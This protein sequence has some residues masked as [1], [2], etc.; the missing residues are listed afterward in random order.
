MEWSR[1]ESGDNIKQR[2][3]STSA[4]SCGEAIYS[5]AEIEGKLSFPPDD[6]TLSQSLD[7]YIDGRINNVK[8]S[9]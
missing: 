8:F 7:R 4:W 9:V 1:R 6:W 2:R 5:G 3:M